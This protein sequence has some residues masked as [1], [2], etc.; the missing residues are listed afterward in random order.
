M[1]FGRSGWCHGLAI[2]F[3]LASTYLSAATRLPS[4][5]AKPADI[6]QAR[7]TALQNAVATALPTAASAELTAGDG[8]ASDNFGYSVALSGTTALVGALYH[9]VGSNSNQGAAYVFTFNGS[10][11]I[12]QQELTASDGAADDYFGISVALSGTTALVGAPDHMVG[13][14]KYQGTAYVFTFNGS[15][16]V[17][18]QELT[19]S[20]GAGSDNFGGSVALSG[21]SALVGAHAKTIGPNAEQGAA[22]VFT[23][24][25]STWIQQQE[26]TASDGAADDYFG[27]SVALSGTSAVVGAP[28]HMVGLNSAEGAAYIFMYNGSTW[29]QQ[30]E[31]TA[32]DGA[33]SDYFGFSVALSGTTALVGAHFKTIGANSEQGAA[34]VFTL[35][36]SAWVQQQELTASDGAAYDEFGYSVALSGTT[37]LVGAPD[38]MVGSN[39]LQGA[40]YVFQES[41]ST[42]IQQELTA[43]DGAAFDT[44]GFSVSL[45]G[46]KALVGAYEETIGSNEFQGAAYVFTPVSD[47]IFCDGFDGTGICK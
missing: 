45:S 4:F 6:D 30:P 23:F 36:G 11:W 32:G 40:A 29:T 25:G 13:S 8:A 46:T 18:Q 28:D 10:T 12:Q 27:L 47:T 37:A 14:N 16:W 39:A 17:Q 2:L 20:D 19:T 24:N 1:T 35:S 42:W 9:R 38:H 41:G 26:L 31:L 22:F 34:Y 44:L 43:S 33:A 5:P 21:T 15:T 3:V 7:W